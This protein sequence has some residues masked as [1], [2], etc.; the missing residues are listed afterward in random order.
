MSSNNLFSGENQ[1]ERLDP[2]W[3]V[4]FTDGEG[5]FSISFVKNE[6][7]RFGYQVFTEFV[8]TQGAKSLPT[9]EAIQRFFQCGNIYENRR[10][11]NH[12]ENIY[13]YCV[14]DKRELASKICPFFRRFPLQTAK[15]RDF[16]LFELGLR[17][18]E[19]KGHLEEAGFNEL[20]AIAS[21]MNRKKSRILNDQTPESI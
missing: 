7:L 15:R 13:R 19:R 3:L 12:Q 18:I 2:M 11:D 4:G 5:C 21:Q 14:R 6:E 9:L 1:Q 8:I 17:I 10:Y 16:E 20:R